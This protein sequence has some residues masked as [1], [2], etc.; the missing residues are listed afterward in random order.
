MIIYNSNENIKERER[1]RNWK[2]DYFFYFN[3]VDVHKKIKF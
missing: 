3:N 1:K 2:N